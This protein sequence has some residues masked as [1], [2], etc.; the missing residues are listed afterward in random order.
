MEDQFKCAF[1]EEPMTKE[2]FEKSEICEKCN[3]DW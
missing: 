1:C 2:E 3:E